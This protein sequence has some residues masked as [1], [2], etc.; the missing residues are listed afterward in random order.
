MQTFDMKN[1][2]ERIDPNLFSSILR[3]VLGLTFATAG[4]F[5]HSWITIGF[6]SLMFIT[7]FFR[8]RRCTEEG[9]DINEHR[10][11]R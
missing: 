3:W 9:C 2:I 6:G 5:Y 4:W 10:S 7:G 8:P 1:P 11:G